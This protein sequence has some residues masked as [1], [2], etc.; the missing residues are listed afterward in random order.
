MTVSPGTPIQPVLGWQFQVDWTLSGLAVAAESQTVVA[1][2]SG[3][4][5]YWLNPDGTLRG[6]WT[7]PRPIAAA[8]HSD[9][10]RWIAAVTDEGRLYWFD[11]DLAEPRTLMGIAGPLTIAFDAQGDYLAATFSRG[12]NLVFDRFGRNVAAFRSQRP[13]RAFVFLQERSWFVAGAEQGYVAMHTLYGRKRW[14]SAFPGTLM[15]LAASPD[16]ERIVAAAMAQG[17]LHFDGA[18]QSL[19]S[20]KV[21]DGAL[22]VSID[23]T[24]NILLAGT[25]GRKVVLFHRGHQRVWESAVEAKIVGLR[26]DPLARSAWVGMETGRIARFDLAPRQSPP[27]AL[28]AAVGIASPPPFVAVS[29]ARRRPG[30]D[31][32][33]G[34]SL[35]MMT[36]QAA[37]LTLAVSDAPVRIGVLMPNKTLTVFDPALPGAPTPLHTSNPLAGLGRILIASQGRVLALSDRQLLIYDCRQNASWV[38]PSRL[39]EVTHCRTLG[40]E[41]LI[42]VQ[43]RD[44][45]VRQGQSGDVHWLIPLSECV[46]KLEASVQCIAATT[47]AGRLVFFS[48]QG[49]E[50]AVH[51]TR[52]IEAPLLTLIAGVFVTVDRGDRVARAFDGMARLLWE[53]PVDIEPWE[54]FAIGEQ[55]IVRDS[56]GNARLIEAWGTVTAGR[57]PIISNDAYVVL[58]DGKAGRVFRQAGLLT[59]ADFSGRTLWRLECSDD[60][61]SIVG[62]N[63]GIGGLLG[64]R[65]VWLPHAHFC[66]GA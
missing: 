15:G 28:A 35:G 17:V 13:Y 36:D 39:I 22:A 63:Q 38:S 58:A 7:C 1:W 40:A 27:G 8:T 26:L 50:I 49:Q 52:G 42:L 57:P 3:Q 56:A 10:G 11:A 47:D 65:L 21:D 43:E 61:T 30:L 24:G 59:L 37:R 46:Q 55:A 45:L 54:L 25:A 14:K 20:Q 2:D 66:E 64:S 41:V 5:L 18:G 33:W 16:G 53:R 23:A 48:H 31:D 51:R 62:N 9:D 60:L 6:R 4:S 12:D 44:R 19:G 29:A 32:A 34:V